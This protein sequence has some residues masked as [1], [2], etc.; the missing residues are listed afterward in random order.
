MA[1]DALR[2]V[3]FVQEG[4]AVMTQ[5]MGSP[6]WT[7]PEVR[8]SLAVMI[9]PSPVFCDESPRPIQYLSPTFQAMHPH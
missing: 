8:E 1:S 6:M 5:R 4:S 2:C 7:A 3:R 9:P